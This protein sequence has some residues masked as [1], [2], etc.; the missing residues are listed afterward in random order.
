MVNQQAEVVRR[1]T[2]LKVGT[3]YGDMNV[4]AWE[5][6]A[7]EAELEKNEVIIN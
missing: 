7:W 4:D 1:C 5:L 3:Y 2:D 6:E